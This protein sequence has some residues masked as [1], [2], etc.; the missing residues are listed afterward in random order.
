M[1]ARIPV[2]EAHGQQKR[3]NLKQRLE[4]PSVRL[5]NS[6]ALGKKR[7]NCNLLYVANIGISFH[8]RKNMREIYLY[9]TFLQSIKL[10][11]NNVKKHPCFVKIVLKKNGNFGL[12]L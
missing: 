11:Y 7:K 12:A 9:L 3:E 6:L 10:L 5:K 4:V 8:I 1:S 2:S